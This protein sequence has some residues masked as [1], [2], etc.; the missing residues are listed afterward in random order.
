[1]KVSQNDKSERNA[2][3]NANSTNNDDK[4]GFIEELKKT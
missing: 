2:D 1:M 4:H 3:D